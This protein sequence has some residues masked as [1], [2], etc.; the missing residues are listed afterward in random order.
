MSINDLDNDRP[1]SPGLPRPWTWVAVL[2]ILLLAAVGFVRGLG[3]SGS[4]PIDAI[5]APVKGLPAVASLTAADAAPLPHNDDWSVLSGPKILPP[6]APKPAKAA[7]NDNE[8]GAVAQPA[9]AAQA[10][11]QAPDD[12]ATPAAQ[13]TPSPQPAPPQ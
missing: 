5:L 10:D 7:S 2:L 12:D 9:A 11:S 1:M 8:S 6:P 3:G 4:K 13:P